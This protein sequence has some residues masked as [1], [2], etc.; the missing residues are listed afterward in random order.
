MA[1]ATSPSPATARTRSCPPL[2]PACC[3]WYR[4]PP[5]ASC[6]SSPTPWSSSAADRSRTARRDRMRTEV[7][8]AATRSCPV[9]SA[10]TR[11]TDCVSTRGVLVPTGD[12]VR[13]PAGFGPRHLVV[14]Q[15]HLVAA[16][17]LSGELWLGARDGDGWREAHLIPTSTRE[18]L[19]QPSGIATDGTRVY[20]ANRGVDTISAFDVD[21]PAGTSD[22][23][24]PSSPAAVPGRGTSPSTTDCCGSATRGGHGRGLRRSRR[25]PRSV[26]RWSW[27]CS[28]SDLCGARAR[29]SSTAQA[30]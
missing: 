1:L 6:R 10:V 15:D 17:E 30:V 29:L 11:S 28:H 9:T 16:G 26:P 23:G 27:R 24:W 4:S 19:V 22:R 20:V 13:L 3:R 5:P 8:V 14:A 25:C 2:A 18:G 12:P 21:G 7:V